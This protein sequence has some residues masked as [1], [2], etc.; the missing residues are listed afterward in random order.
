MTLY[1]QVSWQSFFVE[2]YPFKAIEICWPAV[3]EKANSI[4]KKYDLTISMPNPFKF[5]E[6]RSQYYIQTTD[7]KRLVIEYTFD[8]DSQICIVQTTGT[9][10]NLTAKGS[11]MVELV[12]SDYNTPNK[13]GMVKHMDIKFKQGHS[14]DPELSIIFSRSGLFIPV[15]FLQSIFDWESSEA[16]FE[17]K[18]METVSEFESLFNKL[19]DEHTIFQ[20]TFGKIFERKLDL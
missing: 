6:I 12:C 10:S 7:C 16:R 1:I 15:L 17:R 14:L 20:Y 13:I 2:A 11:V 9:I 8:W 18:V 3:A 4:C 19:L 5:N